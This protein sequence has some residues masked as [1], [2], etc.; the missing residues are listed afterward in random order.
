MALDKHLCSIR[1][2]NK[3][4]INFC[5]LMKHS[6]ALSS[7]LINIKRLFKMND[8]SPLPR[9][10]DPPTRDV[11]FQPT[12]CTLLLRPRQQGNARQAQKAIEALCKPYWHPLDAFA[13][14]QACP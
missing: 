9:N 2:I 13:R 7:R 10:S 11:R 12:Q 4:R 3:P 6:V 1:A 14:Q 5:P 8:S